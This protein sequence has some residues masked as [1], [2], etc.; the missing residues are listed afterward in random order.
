M[1]DKKLKAVFNTA[2]IIDG[3]DKKRAENCLLQI[4][5]ILKQFDCKQVP[6]LQISSERVRGMIQVVALPRT[7]MGG[8]P[9]EYPKGEDDK[10]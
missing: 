1:D 2:K 10:D 9:K 3:D 8:I 7:T 4:D 6:V 5:I